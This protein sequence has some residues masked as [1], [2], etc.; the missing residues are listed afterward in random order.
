MVPY[1]ILLE[2]LS[3]CMIL[4]II[5]AWSLNFLLL[6]DPF[7]VYLFHLLLWF[8]L[9]YVLLCV[10]QVSNRRQEAML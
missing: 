8:F 6:L 2:P 4:G 7:A 10:V 5:A 9:D 1:T 3:E